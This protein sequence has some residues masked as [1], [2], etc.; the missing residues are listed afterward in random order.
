V[1]FGKNYLSP[2]AKGSTRRYDYQ[3]KDTLVADI[4]TTFVLSFEPL[5]D[6]N[7]EAMKG[8]LYISTD[9]YAVANVIAAPMDTIQFITFKM[10]QKYVR[11]G[12]TKQWFP[13]Q[14]NTDVKLKITMDNGSVPFKYVSRSYFSDIQVN[15]EIT[16]KGFNYLVREIAP[17]ATLKPDTLWK[18]YRTDTLS[19]RE[20]NSY[21]LWETKLKDVGASLDRATY[22]M[23]YILV[24]EIP[25]RKVSFPIRHL[26]RIN[27]YEGL[28]L[29]LGIKT[30][31][32][33]SKHVQLEANVGFGLFGDWALKYGGGA[34]FNLGNRRDARFR[35]AY[36]Q[37]IDEPANVDFFALNPIT[38]RI[39]SYRNFLV[40]RVDSVRQIQAELSLRAL[41][42]GH[43]FLTL[44]NEYRNPTYNYR[45]LPKGDV[46]Q[47]QNEFNVSEISLGIRYAYGEKYTQF[48]RSKVLLEM[49]FP[50]VT[51][52]VSRG[53]PNFLGSGNWEYTKVNLKIEERWNWRT[54]GATSLTAFGGK[55][56]GDVP[57]SYLY[58]FRGA[59]G[60]GGLAVPNYFQTM[61]LYE[62]TSNEY[63][64]VFLQHNFG[65][66]L[67]K[68][69]NPK[70]WF[71]PELVLMQGVGFGRLSNAQN[72]EII[73]LKVP[74]K[75]FFESGMM[76]N[77]LLFQRLGPIRL[78]YG[79]GI[80]R[81]FGEYI[82][83][84]E[85]KNWSFKFSG[86]ISF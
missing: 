72:H 36:K 55:I 70:S 69:K 39:E 53:L 86:T 84:E 30:N 4:D 28:R 43:I 7:F 2:I 34:Q 11:V 64:S 44:Q 5:A 24:G 49:A 21:R 65:Q 20:A 62:F 13:L 32:L 26:F 29:G 8:L 40:E 56:W 76:L 41:R 83:T 31:E 12:D 61:G 38:E 18:Q 35:I 22:L 80:F 57:Y 46:S 58:N 37:D 48:G 73:D 27:R 52:S 16:K 9:R 51:A 71:Q 81:R 68:P 74:E 59:S 79:I 82:L 10:Q 14:L 19:K 50:V 17:D 60:T 6:K 15:P 75:G 1:M 67:Y 42:H 47:S 77:N 54:L 3:I 23:E 33:Y 25:Y 63:V 85:K 66:L 45:F 78:G